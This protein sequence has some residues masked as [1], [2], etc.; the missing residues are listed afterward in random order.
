MRDECLQ[1]TALDHVKTIINVAQQN[2]SCW[3]ERSKCATFQPLHCQI[4]S[5]NQD[6]GTRWCAVDLLVDVLIKIEVGVDQA[7]TEEHLE[8]KT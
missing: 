8:V 6:R 3:A 1:S 7:K 4:H 2:S 5:G